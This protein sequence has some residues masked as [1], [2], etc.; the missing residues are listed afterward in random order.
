MVL[1]FV[2]ARFA[3]CLLVIWFRAVLGGRLKRPRGLAFGWLGAEL[4][5]GGE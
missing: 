2:S 4:A 5:G 3:Y 1:V